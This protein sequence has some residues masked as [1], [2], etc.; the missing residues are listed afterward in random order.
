MRCWAGRCGMA[1]LEQQRGDASVMNDLPQLIGAVTDEQVL[2]AAAAHPPGTPGV[3]RGQGWCEEMTRTLPD[4]RTT[5]RKLTV[6]KTA[7]RTL[8]NGLTVIAIR[9]PSVP[10]VEMRL[11]IPF[12]KANLARGDVLSET[13]FAGTE[14]MSAV[15]IAAA[16]QEVGGGLG[17]NTDPDRLQHLRQLAGLRP[18][19]AAGDPRRRA[20]VGDVPGRRG[21]HRAGAAGRP[22]PGGADPARAPVPDRAAQAGLRHP[23][24]RHPDADDRAGAR[25]SGRP[26]CGR[27]TPSGCTRTARPWWSS[28]TCAPEKAID[29]VATALGLVGRRE[30]TGDAAADPDAGTR[31]DP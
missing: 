23:P 25:R 12:A 19:A 16:L 31:P 20:A 18:A 3:R 1:V 29:A 10:L 2:A 4:L 11:R 15:E 24:V 14:T 9:R 30:Q 21:H 8:A 26:C 5:N 28:A 13:L 7:E 17:A 22:D 6:P 27:C